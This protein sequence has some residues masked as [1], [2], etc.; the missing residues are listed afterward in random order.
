MFFIA[1]AL[2]MAM[3]CETTVCLDE[4]LA[5]RGD[6]NPSSTTKVNSSCFAE[7]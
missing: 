5:R 6:S 1:K 2:A 4:P 3:N 7:E